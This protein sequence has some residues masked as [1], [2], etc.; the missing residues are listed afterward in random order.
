MITKLEMTKQEPEH[1]IVATIN[2]ASLTTDSSPQDRTAEG[3]GRGLKQ[4][5][6]ARRKVLQSYI[7]KKCIN[8]HK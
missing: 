3:L 7:E 2:T 8:L 1:T 5:C 6:V 4:I